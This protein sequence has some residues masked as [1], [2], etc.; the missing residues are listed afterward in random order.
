ML[1]KRASAAVNDFGGLHTRKGATFRVVPSDDDSGMARQSLAARS[2]LPESS[3]A[4]ASTIGK[5]SYAKTSLCSSVLAALAEGFGAYG[6]ALYPTAD[7]PLQAILVQRR[8][9]LQHS[10][11]VSGQAQEADLAP[12]NVRFGGGSTLDAPTPWYR[13]LP[14]SMYDAA[15]AFWAHWRREREIRKA[16][17]ALAQFDD[18]SLRDMGIRSRSEIEQVVRYCRDC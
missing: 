11:S 17:A 7:F 8:E 14:A 15:V 3:P 4:V 18:R 12:E 16:V 10:G 13:N 1:T 5:D 6:V 2:D 9:A